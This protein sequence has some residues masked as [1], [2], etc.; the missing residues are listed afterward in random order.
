[1][2]TSSHGAS[3][4]VTD[5][6]PREAGALYEAQI[7][8]HSKRPRNQGPLEGATHQAK[9]INPL[10]GDRVTI[11]LRL[12]DGRI[13][14]ATFEARGCAIA[15]ASASMLTEAVQGLDAD[16]AR[17][18]AERLD[19]LVEGAPAGDDDGSL[20][21][22]AGVRRFPSR[23]RCATLPWTTLLEALDG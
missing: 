21:P 20:S 22:L 5:Q 7:V 23:K 12:V 15:C 1:M 4:A 11:H 10:C 19:A 17:A 3:D 6:E 9:G 13:A 18:R 16:G 14:A 8:E 2:E